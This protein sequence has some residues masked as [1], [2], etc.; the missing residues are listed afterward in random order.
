MDR[1]W[2]AGTRAQ[3]FNAEPSSLLPSAHSCPSLWLMVGPSVPRPLAKWRA[4]ASSP[5]LGLIGP[6]IPTGWGSWCQEPT[7]GTVPP[8]R[9]PRCAAASF[10]VSSHSCGYLGMWII[11]KDPSWTRVAKL[12]L[13]KV[14]KTQTLCASK[15]T[16]AII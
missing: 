16:F 4:E 2:Q 13:P 7:K 14:S 15:C 9:S 10:Y 6:V 3:V 8:P 5:L 1:E 12:L 11:L